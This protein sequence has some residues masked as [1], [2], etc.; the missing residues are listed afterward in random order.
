M[1]LYLVDMGLREAKFDISEYKGV[2]FE[3]E[4]DS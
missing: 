4:V 1:G 2:E 3:Y